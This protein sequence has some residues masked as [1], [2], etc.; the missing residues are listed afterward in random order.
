MYSC[1]FSLISALDG[2]GWSTPRP[3]RFTPG[4]ETRYPFYR[5]LGRPQGRSGRVRKISPPPG[6]DPLT[7]QRVAIPT[8][9]SRSITIIIIIIIILG[10]S[11]QLLILLHISVPHLALS[12]LSPHST[13]TIYTPSC[14]SP[15]GRLVAVLHVCYTC[16]THVFSLCG[17]VRMFVSIV[18]NAFYDLE[19]PATFGVTNRILLEP[20]TEP[21]KTQKTWTVPGKTGTN[22]IPITVPALVKESPRLMESVLRRGATST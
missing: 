4:K 13:I 17:K 7:V 19:N 5:W 16:A 22:G 15:S 20:G 2:D 14:S 6:F 21:F 18:R 8:E 9:L 10:H 1:T 11:I 12:S 3:G